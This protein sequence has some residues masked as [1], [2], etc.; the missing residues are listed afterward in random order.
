MS[1][2]FRFEQVEITSQE[3]LSTSDLTNIGHLEKASRDS[4]FLAGTYPFGIIIRSVYRNPDD[5]S[6]HSHCFPVFLQLYL[7]IHLFSQNSQVMFLKIIRM[8]NFSTIIF[9]IT[10]LRLQCSCRRLF[11]RRCSR[12]TFNLV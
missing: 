11:S 8:I 5:V 10:N 6:H 1:F 12:R 7:N 2:H 3:N 4:K 9:M